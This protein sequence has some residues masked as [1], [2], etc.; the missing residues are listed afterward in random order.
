M[1]LDIS[2]D[3]QRFLKSLE[4][5]E[6]AGVISI[7]SV[8]ENRRD[9]TTSTELEIGE[10]LQLLIDQMAGKRSGTSR[11][12]ELGKQLLG[13]MDQIFSDATNAAKNRRT[14]GSPEPKAEKRSIE[15]RGEHK[16][17][18]TETEEGAEQSAFF[19]FGSQSAAQVR[20]VEP[21]GSL[22]TE[23][24]VRIYADGACSMPDRRAGA[25]LV[26]LW[27][28]A[29]HPQ[30]FSHSAEVAATNQIAELVAAITALRLV[31]IGGTHPDDP[32]TEEL[33]ASLKIYSDSKY[34]IDGITSWVKNWLLNGWRNT[35]GEAVANQEHWKALHAQAQLLEEA[36]VHVEWKHLRGHQ[37]DRFN[38]LADQL[39]VTAR[40]HAAI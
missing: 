37:G 19:P 17:R 9:G 1:K 27:G 26:M 32:Q 21:Q 13:E 16:K 5:L 10:D 15:G 30:E 23:L 25:G 33:P 31:A 7:I 34:V 35:K 14:Q 4:R 38:E 18:A 3:K 24:E 12:A 2:K 28:D 6:A 22:N 11:A 39:A 8:V 36:G 20:P 40:Q 29:N